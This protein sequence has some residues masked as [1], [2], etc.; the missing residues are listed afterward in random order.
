M[1]VPDGLVFALFELSH[2]VIYIYPKLFHYFN[3]QIYLHLRFGPDTMVSLLTK[4]VATIERVRSFSQRLREFLN[5]VTRSGLQKQYESVC[6]NIGLIAFLLQTEPK[7]DQ[8][9]KKEKNP[10]LH[11]ALETYVKLRSVAF[12]NE[13]KSGLSRH[14]RPPLPLDGAGGVGAHLIINFSCY[15]YYILP[16]HCNFGRRSFVIFCDNFTLLFPK[17]KPPIL[18]HS[19]ALFLFYRARANLEELWYQILLAA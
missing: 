10:S 4:I 14:Y 8:C 3:F 5:D 9:W 2:F 11:I 19:I 7:H 12:R 1:S 6:E 15:Y 18:S 16:L 13:R 17:Q